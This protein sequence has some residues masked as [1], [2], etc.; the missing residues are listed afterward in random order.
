SARRTY[1]DLFLKL[2]NDTT[3][4]KTKLYFYDLNAK[5]SYK[6]SDNDRIYLSGYYGKDVLGLSNL[7][8]LNWGNATAT[9]RYN[10]IF[11]PKLFSNTSLVYSDYTYNINVNAFGIDASILSVIRD[12]NLKE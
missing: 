11:N 3:L 8:G 5:A 9:L 12:W 7:F 4:K 10:H 1:A 6:L 2:S